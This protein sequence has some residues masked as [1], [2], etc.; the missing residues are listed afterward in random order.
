[1]TQKPKA[2]KIARSSID[3]RFVTE[4]YERANPHTTSV[5]TIPLP[6]RTPLEREIVQRQEVELSEGDLTE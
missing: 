2:R 5:D 4:E 3:G 6:E 1:V